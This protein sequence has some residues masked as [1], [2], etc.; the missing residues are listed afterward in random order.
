MRDNENWNKKKN[1][2]KNIF[3]KWERI[4]IKKWKN[5]IINLSEDKKDIFL[6]KL[7]NKIIDLKNGGRIKTLI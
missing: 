7:N 5:T 6:F 3:I 1:K 2:K 4:K